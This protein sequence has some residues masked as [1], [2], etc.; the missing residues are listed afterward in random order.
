MFVSIDVMI[1][2][3][4]LHLDKRMMGGTATHEAV[5]LSM[6]N[7]SEEAFL[8]AFDEYA[9]GLFRHACFRV[10]RRDRATDITQDTFIKAWDHVR[11]GGE[12]TH[13]KAFLYRV[14]HNL[15]IDEY[16]RIK[17]ASL[18]AIIEAPDSAAE[19]LLKTGGRSEVESKLNDHLLIEQMRKHIDA[20]PETYRTVITLRY[21]NDL[22]PK[23][24]AEILKIS[25]NVASVRVHRGITK[26]K[27]L[28]NFS[29]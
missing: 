22:S 13:W 28:C 16:R 20:L 3:F 15:I 21:V 27:K 29:D 24:I 26:L 6:L 5:L 18:D 14:L 7:H 19:H 17:E 2:T 23:E 10:K 8:Q 25:E 4:P 1:A 11:K 9:D 12:V